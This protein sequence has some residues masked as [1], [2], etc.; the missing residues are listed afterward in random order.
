MTAH[1]QTNSSIAAARSAADIPPQREQLILV[2]LRSAHYHLRK[3][4]C[5]VLR[6]VHEVHE[7]RHTVDSSKHHRPIQEDRTEAFVHVR[8]GWCYL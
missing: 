1:P 4:V 8:F 7:H 5:S 6:K 2:S 3:R